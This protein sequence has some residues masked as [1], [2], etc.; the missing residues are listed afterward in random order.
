MNEMTLKTKVIGV[1]IAL[2]YTNC[3][4][5]DL[6]GNIIAQKSFSTKDYPDVNNFVSRLCEQIVNIAEE[7]G[8]LL[9]MRSVGISAPS[10]NY[11]T[12]C[13]ENAANLP[14]KGVIPLSAILR[15]RLGMS[16]AVANDCHASA[17]GELAFGTAHGMTDFVVMTFKNGGVGSCIFTNGYPHLGADGFAGEIGHTC[18]DVDGRL[19]GCGH[20]GCLERYVSVVGVVQTARELMAQSDKPS[21]MRNI[22]DLT[23]PAVTLCCEKGDELALETYYR[24][25]RI[26]GTALA[27]YASMLNPQAIII[28]GDILAATKWF[29]QATREAME[30]HVFHNLKGGKVRI[31]NSIL[32]P[33]ESDLLGAAALAWSVKEYSLFK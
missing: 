6:R 19:C 29:I 23:A 17:L 33:K 18:V 25:G 16:V 1:D 3:A 21:L 8:G 7:N 26:L 32:D 10:S 15:D 4:V 27:N 12:G 9:N 22:H 28:A 5:V 13:I 30:E 20:R 2:D 14:W 24:T 31:L 11:R